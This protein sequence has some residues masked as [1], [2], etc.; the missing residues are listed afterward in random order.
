MKKRLTLALALTVGLGMVAQAAL[1]SH[2]DGE[3]TGSPLVDQ[4][5][6]QTAVAD[7]TGH[8]YGVAGPGTWGT[9]IGQTAQSAWTLSSSDSTELNALLNDFS[10]AA[11][12]YL[13]SAIMATKTGANA[14]GNR[15]IGD[16]QA[17]NGDAWALGYDSSNQQLLFTKN[18]VV[19][20]FDPTA[21]SLGLDGW[22]HVAVTVSSTAGIS[23]YVDGALSGVNGNTANVVNTGSDVFSVG[24]ASGSGEAQWFAGKLD[25]VRVYNSVIDATE[26]TAISTI[27]EPA[28]LGMIAVFGGGILFIRR[29]LMM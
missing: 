25:E 2:Y 6:G 10:V 9:A 17:W 8:Q 16:D 1:I 19:D 11:W 7:G 26:L 24:R 5:G 14:K 20:A 3:G 29:K 13:D 4:V 23:F 18:G 21:G 27:P 28:T 12:V 22:H 15:I